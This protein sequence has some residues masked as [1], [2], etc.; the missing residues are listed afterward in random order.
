MLPD[1]VL[2]PLLLEV[3]ELILLQVESNLGATTEWGAICVR[4]N[5]KSSSAGRLPDVLLVVVVLRYN[6][7]A[8]GNEIC[9]VKANTK[10]SN[11]GNIGAS[12][13]GLHEPL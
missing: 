8:F 2:N 1:G 4:G 5:R 10:L 7:G 13:H 12:A 9:G 3:L 11:H 6:L